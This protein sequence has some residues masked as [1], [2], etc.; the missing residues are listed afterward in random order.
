MKRI[1]VAALNVGLVCCGIALL[2]LCATFGAVDWKLVS[3]IAP[4][5]LVVIGLIGLL[6]SR[7]PQKGK[8]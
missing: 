7:K 3:I 6:L 4:L 2:A 5:G 8:P 1:D